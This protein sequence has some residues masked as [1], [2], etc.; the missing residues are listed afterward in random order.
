[1]LQSTLEDGEGVHQR[2]HC[3]RENFRE[4]GAAPGGPAGATEGQ[5]LAHPK[6]AFAFPFKIVVPG[7]CRWARWH[8]DKPPEGGSRGSIASAKECTRRAP[9]VVKRASVFRSYYINN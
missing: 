5:P 9:A 6:E 3:L 2:C 1:M 7:S 4:A 8:E